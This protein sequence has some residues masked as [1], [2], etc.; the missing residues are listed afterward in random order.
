MTVPR[1][2]LFYKRLATGVRNKN[3]LDD[4][5]LSPK[6]IFQKLTFDFN[7]KL[8]IIN[9]PPNADDVEGRESL[10]PNNATRTRI[11]RDCT[12]IYIYI[13]FDHL[14]FISNNS[15]LSFVFINTKLT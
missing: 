14:Y 8:L 1:N 7:N 11:H 4:G 3:A 9:L 12:D 6:M 10:D 5:A 15:I 13:S 2:R